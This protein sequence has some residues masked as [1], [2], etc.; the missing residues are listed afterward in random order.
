MR[1]ASYTRTCSCMDKEDIPNDIISQQNERIQEYIKKRKWRLVK[2][3]SDRKKDEFEETAYLQMKQDAMGR[4]FDCVVVDSMFRCGR[5]ANVAA[6]LFKS[7]FLP[8][9]LHIA[10]VEDDFCTMD[11]TEQEAIAYLDRKAYEY[12]NKVVTED[13]RKYNETRKYPKYGFVY[14]EGKMEL[15]I[16]LKVAEVI[17]RIF[18]MACEGRSCLEIAEIL[19]AENVES[20]ANYF[21]RM[22]GKKKQDV[23]APWKRDQIKRILYN[24]QYIGEWKRTI[25]GKMKIFPCPKIIDLEVF[26]KAQESLSLR[27]AST[28]NRGMGTLNPFSGRIVDQESGIAMK[29]Y[30]HQRL[31]IKVFRLS[32][33][34]PAEISYKR[35]N[36]PFDEVYQAVYRIIVKENQTAKRIAGMI[37]NPEWEDEKVARIQKVKVSAKVVFRTM[38]SIEGRNMPLYNQML[39]G[40]ISEDEYEMQKEINVQEFMEWDEKLELYLEEIKEIE[41]CFSQKNPWIKM[42]SEMVV[43]EKITRS[44][45]KRWIERVESFRYERIEVKFKNQEWKEMLPERWMEESGDGTKEQKKL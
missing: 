18:Q 42:F 14:K 2:K 30:P 11:V 45:V 27:S 8:A 24:R 23:H 39:A 17:R 20:S 22:F 35:G 9:G 38:L 33:P 40:N 16:D 15:E 41:T 36:I 13:M 43:P 25:D 37:G 32:Y 34:K 12:K 26:Q 10:V 44:D 7:M 3:Y 6:E 4:M 5:N 31:K 28:S 29:L 1:C 21:N 19:T